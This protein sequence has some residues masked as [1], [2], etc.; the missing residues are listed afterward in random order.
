M[1]ISEQ[2]TIGLINLLKRVRSESGFYQQ[3]EVLF[4]GI[5]ESSPLGVH[6]RQDLLL[7]CSTGS[8]V[9]VTGSG[10]QEVEWSHHCERQEN[11]GCLC[12]RIDNGSDSVIPFSQLSCGI[13]P[14]LPSG[15][16]SYSI[17]LK[18]HEGIFAVWVFTPEST[19]ALSEGQRAEMTAWGE[20]I[21]TIMQNSINTLMIEAHAA[22]KET[23]WLQMVESL[24]LVGEF[25]DNE[26]GLHTERVGKYSYAIAQ[27]MGLSEKD[28]LLIGRAAPLHD[29]GKVG[30]PDHILLKPDVLTDEEFEVMK[31]HPVISEQILPDMREMMTVVNEICLYHHE[32][33]DGKGYPEQLSGEQIPL[34][35]RIVKIADIYDALLSSRPYKEAWSEENTVVE[36]KRIS[37]SELDPAVVAAFLRALPRLRLLRSLY[38][39]DILQ[40]DSLLSSH[41]S[42]HFEEQGD[43]FPWNDSYSVG[44]E[45]VDLHH[46]YLIKLLN[47]LCRM[48]RHQQPIG[49]VVHALYELRRYAEIHF[50]AEEQQMDCHDHP[51]FIQHRQLH[52]QFRNELLK[53]DQQLMKNPLTVGIEMVNYLH[54]WLIHHIAEMDK[55]TFALLREFESVGQPEDLAQAEV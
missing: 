38:S 48:I 25:R 52:Q 51:L 24:T 42:G 40:S 30:I 21:A 26:T 49:K 47:G 46:R 53:Y 32:R 55:E 12:T 3:M 8:L 45:T 14:Q 39:E 27:E 9:W 2:P 19:I 29:L 44:V 1:S 7:R 37:G 34:S 4:E 11:V 28:A 54:D 20:L 6:C 15:K 36:I 33:W 41:D 43:H 16:S 10:G 35:A 22:L 23:D 18:N 17:P 50:A 13:I 5:N 31:Q